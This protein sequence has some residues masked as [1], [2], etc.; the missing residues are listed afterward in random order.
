MLDYYKNGYNCAQS[1]LKACNEELSLTD[2]E[3]QLFYKKEYQV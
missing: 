2:N 1:I 3:K